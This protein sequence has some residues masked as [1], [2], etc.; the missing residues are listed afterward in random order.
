M[1]LTAAVWLAFAS[2]A[3]GQDNVPTI[4]S[5]TWQTLRLNTGISSTAEVDFVPHGVTARDSAYTDIG[6]TDTIKVYHNGSRNVLS[7]NTAW[8]NAG[9]VIDRI[10]TVA[11]GVKYPNYFDASGDIIV[12]ADYTITTASINAVVFAPLF[13]FHLTAGGTRIFQVSMSFFSSAYHV[14][15]FAKRWNE[16]NINTSATTVAKASLENKRIRFQALMRPGVMNAGA[17]TVQNDGS[18]VVSMIDLDTLVETV[19]Y[20]YSNTSLWYTFAGQALGGG[21]TIPANNHMAVVGL[22]Y[23][24]LIGEN[25]QFVIE[26]EGPEPTEEP[27]SSLDENTPENCCGSSPETTQGAAGP[28]LPA[29]SPLWTVACA[30][31]GTV[32]MASTPADAEDWDQ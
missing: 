15:L 5:Q 1:R 16:A 20:T 13:G 11:G 27:E 29:V 23:A 17:T 14:D 9:V 19:F 25:E 4:Y 7:A 31:N 3:W 26:T 24:G 28:I 18:L 6:L 32:P 12:Y 22:G 30:G 8:L 10:G 21:E 2:L